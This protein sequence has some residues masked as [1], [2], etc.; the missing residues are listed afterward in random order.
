[1]LLLG[2]MWAPLHEP[3]INVVDFSFFLCH[4]LAH[5]LVAVL[6]VS[7]LA[8][9]RAVALDLASCTPFETRVVA[10]VSLQA[11]APAA[12]HPVSYAW[13]TT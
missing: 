12:Y 2:Q 7:C 4:V 10:V 13:S 3:T 8:F 1:M 9:D 11:A 6:P 5:L